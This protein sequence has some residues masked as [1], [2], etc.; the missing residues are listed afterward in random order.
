[1]ATYPCGNRTQIRLGVTPVFQVKK[2][3]GICGIGIAAIALMGQYGGPPI[4]WEAGSGDRMPLSASF[5]NNTGNLLI[6]NA[7]GD[8]VT[9]DHAFFSPMGTNGR[10]C[11]TCHQLS[12]GMSVTTDR[13]AERWVATDGMDPVF[14]VVDGAN[15]PTMPRNERDSH[16]LLLDHGLFR[17]SQPWPAAGVTPEFTIEVVRDP[18]GCNT[19][20]DY[21]LTAKTPTIS[22]YRRPRVVGNFR[23][24][25]D[26]HG[27]LT[28]DSRATTLEAQA[29]DAIL[30][31]EQG[32]EKSLSP[33][34]L[35]QIVDYEKQL[36]IAQSMDK[37]G[38]DLAEVTG[39][40]GLGAWRLG[41]GKPTQGNTFLTVENWNGGSKD[42]AGFR[43]SVARGS[44]LFASREF[45]IR[46]TAHFPSGG[47][48]KGTCATCHNEHMTGANLAE[49]WMDVGSNEPAWAG[50]HLDLP[51]FRITCSDTAR[52]HPQ[53]GRV[54]LTNDPG[55]ALVTGKC[56]DVGSLVIQQL[57]AL[58]AR[59]PYFTAGTAKNLR[60]V[61]D[62]YDK[63]FDAHYTEQEKQDLVNFLRVL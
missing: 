28:A 9:R 4:W 25:A 29:I 21:G 54:I 11:V 43:A 17:I 2:I 5:E 24:I 47:T 6:Y 14:S 22:V 50:D 3:A 44:Q 40:T 41:L 60:E 51:L 20:K 48:L 23:Y 27:A 10:A 58:S 18:T 37:E 52:P 49:P 61:V 55:R 34:D 1:V 57:R 46:D 19:G 32:T 59:A 31:H 33:D 56:R 36:Y 63:R 16:S 62:F 42:Q 45:T 38:G 8:M 30:K 13:L 7:S 39:P 15:C 35:R 26:G 53:F 12:S